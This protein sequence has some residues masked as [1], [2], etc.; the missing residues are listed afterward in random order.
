MTRKP[1]FSRLKEKN[2][3]IFFISFIK[4]HFLFLNKIWHGV[5][6][7]FSLIQT[8]VEIHEIIVV[9]S[10]LFENN[11]KFDFNF[12]C[13]T[14]CISLVKCITFGTTTSGEKKKTD[15]IRKLNR[16]S[17]ILVR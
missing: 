11:E 5:E 8:V 16:I 3:G 6:A 17:Y 1:V 7:M 15:Q 12:E 9:P 14:Y 4:F 10:I 2:R 13:V